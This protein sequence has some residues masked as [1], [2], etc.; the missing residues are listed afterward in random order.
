MHYYT[1]DHL[2]SVREMTTST[3]AIAAQYDYDPF[4][5]A[6]LVSGSNLSDMQY[7]GMYVHQPSG[8]NLTQYRAYDPNTARWISRDPLAHAETLMGPNLYAYVL[9]DPINEVDPLGLWGIG[10]GTV[11]GGNF[12]IGVGDPSILFTP[13]TLGDIGRSSSAT[14]DGILTALTANG[15]FGTFNPNLF[16]QLGNYD[17]CDS[18]AQGSHALGQVAVVAA[19]LYMAAPQGV[20]T[21][22]KML[23]TR[24]GPAG[25][26]V[27]TGGSSLRN[28]VM[29][30]SLG[31]YGLGSAVSST[32]DATALGGVTGEGAVANAVKTAIGQ[33]I[34]K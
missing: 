8:L 12:N 28:Y 16:A 26:W 5:R 21:G 11:N 19:S 32:V 2:G 10:F 17:P 20:A 14:T 25:P 15:L 27:M 33:R 24:W 30:G 31:R 22:G 34:M 13:D 6:T 29:S 23:V 1:R 9:N 18:S 7:A 4:G 3:G